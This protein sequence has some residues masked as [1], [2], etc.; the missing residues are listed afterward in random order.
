MCIN[1]HRL[2][3]HLGTIYNTYFIDCLLQAYSSLYIITFYV[4]WNH[5]VRYTYFVEKQQLTYWWSICLFQW[6]LGKNQADCFPNGYMQFSVAVLVKH[7]DKKKKKEG[8]YYNFNYT[9]HK[10]DQI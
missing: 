10:S 1:T 8:M 2:N 6:D 7:F 3:L 4:C 9:L 5:L